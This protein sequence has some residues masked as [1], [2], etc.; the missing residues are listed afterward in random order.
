MGVIKEGAAGRNSR[1]FVYMRTEDLL[2]VDCTKPG[3]IEK[4]KR[5]LLKINVVRKYTNDGENFS[6]EVLEKCLHKI[7][8]RY[9]Y[10]IQ[11]ITPYYEEADNKGFVMWSYSLVKKENGVNEWRGS[12]SAKSLWEMVPKGLIQVYADIKRGEKND[13]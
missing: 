2:Y 12:I 8:F 1:L 6:I 5:A 9:G 4:L 3:G 10:R 7:I 11:W 13:N